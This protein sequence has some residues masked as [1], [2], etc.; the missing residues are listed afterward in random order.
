MTRAIACVGD[1]VAGGLDASWAVASTL[2]F[3][4]AIFPEVK[5]LVIVTGDEFVEKFWDS[6]RI[7][8]VPTPHDRHSK[9]IREANNGFLADCHSHL[10]AA[11]LP[12]ASPPDPQTYSPFTYDSF[13]LSHL[14]DPMWGH[15]VAV[16]LNLFQSWRA[17]NRKPPLPSFF[18]PHL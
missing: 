18:P 3:G 11:D 12:N 8:A 5:R 9:L 14:G 15:A 4:R 16:S 1:S 6:F 2:R 13:L 7:N 17:P 10:P